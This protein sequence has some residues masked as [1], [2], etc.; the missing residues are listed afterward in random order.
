MVRRGGLSGHQRIARHLWRMC[1]ALVI[2]AFSFFIGQQKVMPEFVRGS[3][4]LFGPPLAVL[5]LMIF[6][7]VYVRRSP[8][9]SRALPS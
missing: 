3:P 4:L 6:W 2:A 9:F 5:A 1:A 7:L 8:R